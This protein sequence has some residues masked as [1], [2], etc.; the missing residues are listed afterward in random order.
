MSY[1]ECDV[2]KDMYSIATCPD[3]FYVWADKKYPN[4]FSC[5]GEIPETEVTECFWEAFTYN[6]KLS[7]AEV[8]R[9]MHEFV[10]EQ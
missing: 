4:Y 6:P 7:E 5:V 9:I 1:T 2:P 8:T 10:E 3:E